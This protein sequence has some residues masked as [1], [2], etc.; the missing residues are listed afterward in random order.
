MNRLHVLDQ[1]R[2][3]TIASML[4]VTAVFSLFT[5]MAHAA[6]WQECSGNKIR[7]N[8]SRA[9]MYISTTSFPAGSSWDSRLQNA[10][11]HWNNVKGSG[12]NFFVGRDTDGSHS[13]GNGVNE[14]YFSSTE[15][16]GALAVTFKRY[17]C[18]WFFGYHYGIDETDIAFNTNYA[19]STAAFNY[20]SLGSPYSFEGVALHELGHALGLNHEDLRMATMNS[21]YPNSG[22]TGYYKEWDPTGDDRVGARILYPDG[23]TERDI[24]GLA[25]KRTGAGTSGLVNSP[26]SAA[27]GS[28]VTIE[29]T[30][31]NYGTAS[32][33]FNIGFYLS[34]NNYISTFDR[35][36][37]TNFGASAGS[38]GTGTFAR[39][40]YI[41]T[42]VAPGTYY[43]GFL[44]DPN[45]AFGEANEGNNSQP[46]PRT[47]RIY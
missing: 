22:P 5:T 46:M 2:V 4:I 6:G 37:G 39:T 19:W 21:F 47:I 26:A 34:T 20:A 25:L 23:T 33:S 41:P 10:M 36:L 29:Y 8:G 43:L 44:L 24:A 45:N 12:F 1:S 35:L 14:V 11:W 15:V 28:Y 38:G 7:W 42:T 30:F 31:S 9:D 17:H 18:Y 40:L 3:V 13:S 27:R 32:E 16:G